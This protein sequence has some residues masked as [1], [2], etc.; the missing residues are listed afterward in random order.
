MIALVALAACDGGDDAAPP[1]LDTG[2][3]EPT[4]SV[5]GPECEERILT[6]TP[7]TGADDWYWRDAPNGTVAFPDP[8]AYGIWLEDAIGATVPAALVWAPGDVAF[9]LL[10]SEPLAP[11][12]TYDLVL[13]DC[14]SIRHVEFTTSAFGLPLVEGAASLVDRTFVLDLEGA[15]WE[16]PVG[17]DALFSLYVDDPILLGVLY[18]DDLH[19]DFVASPAVVSDLGEVSQDLDAEPWEFPTADFTNAPYYDVTTPLVELSIPAGG[20]ELTVPVENL[21]LEGT[22]AAS[23]TAI[24]GGRLTGLADTRNLGVLF[25][26]EGDPDVACDQAGDLGATCVACESDGGT[27]C[28]GIEATGIDGTLLP[29]VV[30]DPTP[31][32]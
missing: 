10:P 8:T 5:T 25:G 12:A 3:F 4:T 18:A 15:T 31:P 16:Q 28:L 27:Y 11:L 21:R 24:G 19:I 2:W 6:W 22:F 14:A 32:S 13:T 30:L 20:E 17:L 9:T 29:G 26:S 7:E 23:G 1:L